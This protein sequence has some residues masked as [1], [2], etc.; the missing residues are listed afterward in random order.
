MPVETLQSI[1]H[2]KVAHHKPQTTDSF[3]LTGAGEAG[4]SGLPR[5]TQYFAPCLVRN[6]LLAKEKFDEYPVGTPND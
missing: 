4:M 2:A 3:W 6:P 5:D 1:D